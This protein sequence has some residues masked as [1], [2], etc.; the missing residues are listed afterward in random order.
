MNTCDPHECACCA[1]LQRFEPWW[2]LKFS[3]IIVII[4]LAIKVTRP[5]YVQAAFS[6]DSRHHIIWYYNTLMTHLDN[7]QNSL[8]NKTIFF[9]ITTSTKGSR[10]G[11]TDINK[12]TQ[13]YIFTKAKVSPRC[14]IAPEN[15]H[16]FFPQVNPKPP[17]TVHVP[18]NQHR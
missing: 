3:S 5:Q 8:I 16:H 9:K 1:S 6:Q 12:T 13:N 7:H 17:S 14:V 4:K 18:V 2:L 15:Q 11:M 10:K